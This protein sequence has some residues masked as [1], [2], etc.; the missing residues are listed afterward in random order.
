MS[1]STRQREGVTVLDLQGQIALGRKDIDLPDE[2][3]KVTSAG[4]RKVLFNLAGVK[5]I[6]SSGLADLVAAL[7]RASEMGGKVSLAKPRSNV[8]DLLRMTRVDTL[9]EVYE[10]EDEA[11]EA[12]R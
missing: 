8:A 6:D 12:M 9:F 4:A 7:H 1:V 3:E 11:I 10:T 2:F 5:R